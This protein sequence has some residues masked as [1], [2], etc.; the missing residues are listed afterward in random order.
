MKIYGC[1]VA[2]ACSLAAQPAS[3]YRY[4]VKGDEK[5]IEIT[6]VNYQVTG[7]D[8]VLRMTTH[9]KQV[10]G[11]MGMEASTTT[12]AWKLGVDLKT[13]PI[14]SVTVEGAESR[15]VEESLFVVSRGLEEVD[16]W[17]IYRVANGAHLFDTYVPLVKFSISRDTLT[18]RY[19]GL[20]VPEDN[21]KDA[22][23]REPHVVAVLSY[24]SAAK[25][26]REALITCDDLKQAALLRSFADETRTL[27]DIGG[28]SL[29][30]TFTQNYP[31]P[32]APV[33]VTI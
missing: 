7:A 19:A 16:W 25:V 27:A 4:T 30:L 3:S 29:R 24:A 5:T 33:T 13:K 11:D 15:I 10:I 2:M 17:S 32:P 1:L 9:S 18:M 20:E 21:H 6:N 23:L 8:L 31:S 22:R 14:Y 12:E 26:I 28:K